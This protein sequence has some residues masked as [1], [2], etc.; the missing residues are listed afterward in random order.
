MIVEIV[1]IGN[2]HNMRERRKSP[3]NPR[4]KKVPSERRKFVRVCGGLQTSYSILP[5]GKQKGSLGLDAGTGGFKF[6]ASEFI[7]KGS[8]LKVKI[9]IR[10]KIYLYLEA[11]VKVIWV[12]KVKY[13]YEIGVKFVNLDAAREKK[14]IAY[15]VNM[16]RGT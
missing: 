12:K 1:R 6:I 10:K 5:K 2:M 11:I 8:T 15:I 3:R 4:A 9:T 16:V 7:P 13:H 14:M